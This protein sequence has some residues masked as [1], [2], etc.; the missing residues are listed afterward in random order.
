MGRR[1]AHCT[2]KGMIMP[3]E[4]FDLLGVGTLLGLL[5]SLHPHGCRRLELLGCI[6]GSPWVTVA[7]KT[8]LLT[9]RVLGVMLEC[10]VV[11]CRGEG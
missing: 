5:G 11:A 10:I 4:R 1:C 7:Y 8:H 9:L 3:L 6:L 2:D